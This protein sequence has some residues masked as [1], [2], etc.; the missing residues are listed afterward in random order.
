MGR[1]VV[2]E[3]SPDKP[4][5]RS[6]LWCTEESIEVLKQEKGKGNVIGLSLDT[7]RLEK[8]NLHATF[9]MKT[10]ALRNMAN[11]MLLQ[12]NFVQINGSYK[13]FPEGLRWLCMH[14][15]PLKSIPSDLRMENVVALDLS[16]SSIESFDI[17]YSNVQRV[18]KRQKQLDGS[19]SKDK[20]SREIRN[21]DV[22]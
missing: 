1:F 20:R 2:H 13:N 22:L 11:L 15:F 14:G 8:E 17:C 16:H 6:R 5:K 10:N 21:P 7:Q 9:E 19:C 3:E 12:L 4:W 18:Q